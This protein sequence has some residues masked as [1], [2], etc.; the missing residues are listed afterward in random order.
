LIFWIICYPRD[1][2][3]QWRNA[4]SGKI[5]WGILGYARIAHMNVMPAITRSSNSEIYAVASR[6]DSKLKECREK[7]NNQKSYT[8]YD[9]LLDDPNVEAVYIPLPN[10]LHKEW[11]IKAAQKGKHVLCEKP[12]AMTER[13]SVEMIAACKKNN[14]KFMEAFMYRYTNRTRKVQEILKSGVLGDIKYIN[15]TYRFFLTRMDSIKLKPE[16]GGGSLFDVGCYPINFVGMVTNESPVSVKA[17]FIADKGIDLIFSAVLRYR[18]GIIATINCGFNAF[19]R[20]HSEIIGTKGLLEIPD[21]FLDDE[22]DLTLVTDSGSEKIHVEK[23]D[24]Y[25]SE[26]EDFADAII[27]NRDPFFGADETLRNMKVLEELYAL[28]RKG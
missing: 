13:D 10:A 2:F 17:E 21:T 7:F 16:L 15:S 14:V 23:S 9:E 1:T 5:K 3:T 22:G 18:A 24:R 4:M 20:V 6:D 12:A 8:S 27:N 28:V 25:R 19:Q 26:V 11:T